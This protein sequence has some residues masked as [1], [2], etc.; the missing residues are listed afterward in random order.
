[1]CRT[2]VAWQQPKFQT[3]DVFSIGN[4]FFFVNWINTSRLIFNANKEE[5]SYLFGA[6][7]TVSVRKNPT[8]IEGWLEDEVSATEGVK[9]YFQ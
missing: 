4:Q 2:R 5:F 3:F 8:R 6:C 9:G 1:M 7:T